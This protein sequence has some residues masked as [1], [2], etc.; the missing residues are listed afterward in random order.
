MSKPN[1]KEDQLVEIDHLIANYQRQSCMLQLEIF[2][3]E[4]KK[5]KLMDKII[6]QSVKQS[7]KEKIATSIANKN[8]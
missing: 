5:E 7:V 6:L 4:L 2:K 8:D 1:K 3:L